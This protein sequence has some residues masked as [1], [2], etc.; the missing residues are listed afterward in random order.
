[1]PQKIPEPQEK[2]DQTSAII[3]K[4]LKKISSHL[5]D[6]LV[7]FITAIKSI[8]KWNRPGPLFSYKLRYIVGFGL[9]E[10]TISTNPKPTIYRNLYEKTLFWMHIG[11][12]CDSTSQ[13]RAMR[14]NVAHHSFRRGPIIKVDLWSMRCQLL[15]HLLNSG[16]IEHNNYNNIYYSLTQKNAIFLITCYS[17]V[18]RIWLIFTHLKLWVAVDR[19]KFK[20]VKI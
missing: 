16:C 11:N 2:C 13:S 5:I 10:M 3:S 1:M 14:V 20:W 4:A 7:Y 19:H 9:V 6:D 17:Q 12:R 15:D 18:K 8:D